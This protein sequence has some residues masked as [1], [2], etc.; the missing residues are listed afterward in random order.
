M[1]NI[2]E[3]PTRDLGILAFIF[4]LGLLTGSL[5]GPHASLGIIVVVEVLIAVSYS[6]K[7]KI[8][9]GPLIVAIL[10][11]YLMALSLISFL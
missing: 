11:S 10:F 9:G 6:V 7:D 1:N 4:F 2:L 8:N 5:V 3:K